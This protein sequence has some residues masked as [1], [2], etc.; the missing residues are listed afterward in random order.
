MSNLRIEIYNLSGKV[1][2]SIIKDKFLTGEKRKIDITK[3]QMGMYIL[4]AYSD[5]R[6]NNLK[7]VKQ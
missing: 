7:F 4:R 1:I 3:L 5:E 2:F 6:V